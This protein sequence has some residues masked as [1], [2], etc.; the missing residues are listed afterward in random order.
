MEPHITINGTALTTAQA[1][2]VRVALE[3][4]AADLTSQG[5]GNDDHGRTMTSACIARIGEIR[6]LIR[7][8][9]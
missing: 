1:M 4:F 2:T 5:L 3:S 8:T 9:S 7:R 6:T